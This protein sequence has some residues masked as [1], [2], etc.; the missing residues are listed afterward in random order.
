M[1]NGIPVTFWFDGVHEDYHG[2][3]D[4]ADKID[5][6]KMEKVTRTILLTLWELADLKRRPAVDKTLPPEL[7]ER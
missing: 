7:T 5:Y 2:V 3:G 4:H 1:L 6:Q